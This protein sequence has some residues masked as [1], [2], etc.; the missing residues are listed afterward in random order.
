MM[1]TTDRYVSA[2]DP[3]SISSSP[4]VAD[5]FRTIGAAPVVRRTSSRP[6]G[7]RRRPQGRSCLGYLQYMSWL[8]VIMSW[9][10][11]SRLC[12]LT[13]RHYAA[14]R[15]SLGF[16]QGYPLLRFPGHLR[17]KQ[18]SPLRR[19]VAAAPPK[20]SRK[21]PAHSASCPRSAV[22]LL[23]LLRSAWASRFILAMSAT[24]QIAARSS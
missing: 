10:P 17:Q 23:G 12:R 6:D 19:L 1:P 15:P 7:A 8:E 9:G 4:F 2:S 16:F 21:C 13:C 5:S 3:S 14:W 24:R 18:L 11:L 20:R 22:P